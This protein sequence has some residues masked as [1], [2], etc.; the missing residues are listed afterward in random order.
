[1]PE[2]PGWGK[3]AID[4]MNLR[5]MLMLDVAREMVINDDWTHKAVTVR[6]LRPEDPEAPPVTFLGLNDPRA[7]AEVAAAGWTWRP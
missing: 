7:I 1:M 3:P 2:Q 4:P 5:S 6:L